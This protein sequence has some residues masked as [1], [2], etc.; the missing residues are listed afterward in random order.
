MITWNP[1]GKNQGHITRLNRDFQPGVV[2]VAWSVGEIDVQTN[3]LSFKPH[4]Q[5]QKGKEKQGAVE[6]IDRARAQEQPPM[7]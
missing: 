4:R 5:E 6:P 7:Q 3:G 1:L 2:E